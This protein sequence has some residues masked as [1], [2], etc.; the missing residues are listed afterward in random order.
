[1]ND[2]N[3]EFLVGT[4][5]DEPRYDIMNAILI[6]ISGKHDTDGTDNGLIRMLT[7]LFDERING[8]DKIKRLRD[9]YGL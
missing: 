1:M 4:N 8:T 3:R 6:N 5:T 7:D 9:S 2:I